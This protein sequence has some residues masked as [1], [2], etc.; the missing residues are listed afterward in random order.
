MSGL[1][2]KSEKDPTERYRIE[3]TPIMV[4][5][6]IINI[7]YGGQV[8]NG[9]PYTC[10]VYDSSKVRVVDVSHGGVIGTEMGFTGMWEGCLSKYYLYCAWKM[11]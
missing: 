5:P 1:I 2:T 4:G 11:Y 9:C 3:F 6:H 10:Q 8:I 7:S